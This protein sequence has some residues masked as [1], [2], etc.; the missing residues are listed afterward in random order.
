MPLISYSALAIQP[1]VCWKIV[2]IHAKEGEGRQLQ[3]VL[4]FGSRRQ[5][6]VNSGVLLWRRM[7]LGSHYN[8]AWG[9]I[10]VARS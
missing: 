10:N 3:R 6:R 2:G 8:V 7:N 5:G 4:N 9:R 1:S